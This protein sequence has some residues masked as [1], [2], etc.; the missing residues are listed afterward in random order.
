MTIKPRLICGTM[1]LLKNEIVIIGNK[2]EWNGMI[3]PTL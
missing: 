3:I 2:K 1:I